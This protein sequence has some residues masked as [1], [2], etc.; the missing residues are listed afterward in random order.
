MYVLR[1]K[2]RIIH[3]IIHMPVKYSEEIVL[4]TSPD[5]SYGRSPSDKV[6]AYLADK[7]DIVI[8]LEKKDSIVVR[9]LP[10]TTLRVKI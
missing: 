6:K 2:G 10:K 1:G 3:D 8:I 9:G 4:K 7:A 5:I